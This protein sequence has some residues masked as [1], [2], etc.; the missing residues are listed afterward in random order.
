MKHSARAALLVLLVMVPA[1]APGDETLDETVSGTVA[2]QER[3]QQQQEDWAAERAALLA[4]YNTAKANV[5]Y[6]EE[7]KAITTEEADALRESVEELERRL[8]ES[9][10]LQASLQDTLNVS[11]ARLDDWVASDLP[12]L[13]A[14]RE[15]RVSSLRKELAKPDVSGAEKLR[16]L[17]ET[18][19]V[20]AEYGSTVEVHQDGIKLGSGEE[21]FVDILRIGR[22][23]VF[24]RTPDGE[25]AGEFDR[26][27]GQWVELPGKYNRNIGLAMEM[28]SRM[29]PVELIDL[30]LGRIA[31]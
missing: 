20:E 14:E 3:T 31:P 19:A 5:E 6:L 10:R 26:A 18:L 25:R 22:I 17:L 21:L 16:R 15:V 9:A 13:Q 2:I 11:M 30:P 24:W 8:D 7:R 4:R 28:A 23:S 1:L 29:R 12:F 27:G